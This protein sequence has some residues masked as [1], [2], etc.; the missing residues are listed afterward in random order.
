MREKILLLRHHYHYFYY[1]A[2]ASLCVT[3]AYFIYYYLHS[4]TLLLPQLQPFRVVLS[5]TTL[6]QRLHLLPSVLVTLLAQEASVDAIW[7]HVALQNNTMSRQSFER[8]L[9]REVPPVLALLLRSQ[10]VAVG[11]HMLRCGRIHFVYDG[12]DF[13]P[14]SKLLGVLAHERDP[15]TRIITVDDDILYDRRMVGTLLR[16]GTYDSALG[17]SCEELPRA[18]SRGWHLISA[19]YSWM[20]PL[21]TVLPCEGWLHGYQGVLYR[22]GLFED[23]V[24]D[25]TALPRGCFFADDV[26]LAGYLASKGI[27]RRVYPHFASFLG[28]TGDTFT[29]LPKNNTGALSMIPDTMLHNQWPCVRHFQWK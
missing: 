28:I 20:Y 18:P 1:Y 21:S 11:A 5:L 12:E 23:D 26:R 22:R 13:G 7:V 24:F 19:G 10:C 4:T 8:R 16:H 25:D 9:R 29:V 17:F 27:A 14:A 15:E 6:P 3:V 2:V